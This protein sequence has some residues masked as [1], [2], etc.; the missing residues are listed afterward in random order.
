VTALLVFAVGF[1]VVDNYFIGRSAQEF[2]EVRSDGPKVAVLPCDNL[3]P[4]PADAYFA[5]GIHEEILNQLA[6][7]SGLLV[8]ART[9]VMQ[10]AE[11]RPSVP[12]IAR[13]LNASAVME[14]SVRYAGDSILVTAQ[15]IDPESDSHV[16]SE[17]YPG[18]LSDVG[19][20]FAMQAD[21]AMN[22]ANALETEFSLAEREDIE[23]TPTESR[24]AY[25]LYLRA[26][27]SYAE[28][29]FEEAHRLL[30]QALM[31]DQGFALAYA[32]KAM[33]YAGSVTEILGSRAANPAERAELEALTRQYADR[34]LSLDANTSLA[35]R[36]LA[37]LHENFWRWAAARDAY[38]EALRLN[39]NDSQALYGYAWFTPLVGEYDR[40][41]ELSERAVS[42]NPN[43]AEALWRLGVT[44]L[45]AGRPAAALTPLRE[46]VRLD[47]SFPLSHLWNS[48]AQ[49]LAGNR[50]EALNELRTTER[51]LGENVVPL[52]LANLA[53]AYRQLGQENDAARLFEGYQSAAV[54]RDY[55]PG[56]WVLALLAIGENDEALASLETVVE[57]VANEEPD[58]GRI[59]VML[60]K[61]NVYSDPVLN[62]PRFR[63]LRD[64]IGVLD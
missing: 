3:S 7:L 57:R 17:T 49:N 19:T 26:L 46:A 40:A 23:K 38:E 41:I 34:A 2:V 15:L 37:S 22:I 36:A 50:A 27:N 60:I 61:S 54:D 16:W 58:E 42:L 14:C 21:I 51:L 59:S 6:K 31:F 28:A 33:M 63:A 64:R 30:D 12:Q 45:Y 44:N 4:N 55:G 29:G 1:L 35:H 5:A 20:L 10:Y 32:L 9:S 52:T 56:N 39:P 53:Y 13:E 25:A 43:S 24:E 11:E 48:V 62:E 47:P 8:I 18:N